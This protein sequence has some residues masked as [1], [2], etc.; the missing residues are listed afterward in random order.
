VSRVPL[1][2]DLARASLALGPAARSAPK[3]GALA[4]RGTARSRCSSCQNATWIERMADPRRWRG[5]DGDDPARSVHESRP[6][7]SDSASSPAASSTWL[8]FWQCV[9]GRG[10]NDPSR[11]EP[12]CRVHARA[13]RRSPSQDL[14]FDSCRIPTPV[15]LCTISGEIRMIRDSEPGK[16]PTT[17]PQTALDPACSESVRR[18]RAC[19][20]IFGKFGHSSRTA[21]GR[22][23]DPPTR[24]RGR[25]GCLRR[26][27]ETFPTLG[28]STS[29][30]TELWRILCV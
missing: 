21:D 22:I 7:G 25:R 8:A 9:A 27:A 30:G 10:R 28:V 29:V 2:A 6:S 1:H 12:R 15:L 26:R 5:S 19:R 4:P 23:A 11:F 14:A 3:P 13:A 24:R 17:G 18:I 20:P 16:P